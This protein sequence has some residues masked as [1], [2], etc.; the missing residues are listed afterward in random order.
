MVEKWVKSSHLLFL[1]FSL[2]NCNYSS[3]MHWDSPD[4]HSTAVL[5]GLHWKRLKFKHLKRIRDISNQTDRCLDWRL[6]KLK[7]DRL[8]LWCKYRYKRSSNFLETSSQ[9]PGYVLTFNYFLTS[10]ASPKSS[11]WH[12]ELSP[13]DFDN[14]KDFFGV[15]FCCWEGVAKI[16][17]NVVIDISNHNTLRSYTPFVFLTH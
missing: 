16:R 3:I 9:T 14:W 1:I 6:P 2:S 5:G 4:L 8:Y 12:S 7:L 17:E 11:L 13:I 15:C 10:V